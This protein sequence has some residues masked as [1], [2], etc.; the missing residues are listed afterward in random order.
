MNRKD[1]KHKDEK[2]LKKLNL[3]KTDNSFKKI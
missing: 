2:L 3:E 1:T